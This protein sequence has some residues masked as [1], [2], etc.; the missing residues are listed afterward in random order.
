MRD[1]GCTAATIL[2]SDMSFTGTKNSIKNMTMRTKDIMTAPMISIL[3]LF[4]FGS[5]SLNVVLTHKPVSHPTKGKR[6]DMA[7]RGGNSS[8][9]GTSVSCT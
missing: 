4:F 8:G 1:S 2:V 9:I 6:S 7:N 3:N 5:S